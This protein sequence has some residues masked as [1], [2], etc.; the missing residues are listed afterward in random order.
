MFHAREMWLYAGS[1]NVY[2]ATSSLNGTTG[3]QPTS[4][5]T[6]H[7]MDHVTTTSFPVVERQRAEVVISPAAFDDSDDLGLSDDDDDDDD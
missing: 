4:G 2:R 3:S 7:V 5:F 1:S 6:R